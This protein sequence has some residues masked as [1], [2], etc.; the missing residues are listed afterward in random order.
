[1]LRLYAV[2]LN[3]FTGED[4]DDDVVILGAATVPA[5]ALPPGTLSFPVPIP[6]PVAPAPLRAD[7]ADA[8][9]ADVGGTLP[10]LLDLLC[11][12]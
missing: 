11:G 8:E 3:A 6:L 5:L 7:S 9:L 2:P 4:D 1:M 10:K 12:G